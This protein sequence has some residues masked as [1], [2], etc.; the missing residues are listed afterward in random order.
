MRNPLKRLFFWRRYSTNQH[1]KY[2][3]GR[4]Y[5]WKE[6]SETWNHPR[7]T[8]LSNVLKQLPFMS[9]MEIG[10]GSGPNLINLLRHVQGKQLGGV[11]INPEAIKVANSIFHG[12]YF[13]VGSAEHMLVSD[14]STD[15]TLTDSFLMYVGPLK[16][17]KYLKEIKRITRDF[18]VLAE[19]HHKSWFKRQKLR[20]FSGRHAYNYKQLLLKLGCYDVTLVK[21]PD[22]EQDNDAEFRYIIIARPPKR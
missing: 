14:R 21:V 7:R 17:K 22:F 3:Q 15:V 18:I 4:V 16:I 13:K 6:Y 8:F 1:K 12:G 19:Y 5:G 10:C 20:I 9:V 11:D 2:W